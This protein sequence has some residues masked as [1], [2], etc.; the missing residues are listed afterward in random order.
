MYL[1]A[2]VYVEYITGE[3]NV[4]I[5]GLK[6]FKCGSW[7]VNFRERQVKS[8]VL[9]T[10]QL[11][12]SFHDRGWGVS[13]YSYILNIILW[14]SVCIWFFGRHNGLAPCSPNIIV[15]REY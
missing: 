11:R 14:R 10:E 6:R 15:N 9:R 12:V 13:Y 4:L 5:S 1:C 8:I 7:C 3:R 2:H